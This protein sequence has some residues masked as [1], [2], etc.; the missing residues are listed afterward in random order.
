MDSSLIDLKEAFS[1]TDAW[2]VIIWS[3]TDLY[4]RLR[5]ILDVDIFYYYICNKRF[6]SLSCL[7]SVD[8]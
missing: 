2:R 8:F 7:E 5:E 3:K 1:D 4:Y 6:E